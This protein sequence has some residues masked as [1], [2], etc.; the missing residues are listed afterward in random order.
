MCIRDRSDAV[1]YWQK[2]RDPEAHMSGKIMV[3]GHTPQAS[4]VPIRNDHA[5][6]IDTKVYADD[7]WLT[8]LDV[9]SGKIWQAN[10]SGDTRESS[11]P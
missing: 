7:G 1:R 11:I 2:F 5:I 10:E 8:C 9:A 3:C 6:C 4:G